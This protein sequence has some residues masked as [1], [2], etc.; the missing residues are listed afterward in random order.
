MTNDWTFTLWS[1][2]LMDTEYDVRGYYFGIDPSLGYADATYTQK[3]E[4]RTI[5]LTVAWDY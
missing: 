5:G 2:N 4:P 1:R 3:G